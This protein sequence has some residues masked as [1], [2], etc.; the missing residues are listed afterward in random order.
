MNRQRRR[1]PPLVHAEVDELR[2]DPGLGESSRLG[3]PREA[4][5]ADASKG[6]QDQQRCR[7]RVGPDESRHA[8][9]AGAVSALNERS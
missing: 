9:A 4:G 1:R 2:L 6:V 8:L 5:E 7:R 3:H